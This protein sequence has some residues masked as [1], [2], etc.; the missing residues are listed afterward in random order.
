MMSHEHCDNWSV[1]YDG[2]DWLVQYPAVPCRADAVM[3]HN[4]AP[5]PQILGVLAHTHTQWKQKVNP[6]KPH[7]FKYFYFSQQ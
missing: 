2:D 1:L 4:S 6:Q 7:F 3:I 5:R